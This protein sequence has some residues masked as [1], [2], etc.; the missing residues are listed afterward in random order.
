MGG[1]VADKGSLVKDEDGNVVAEVMDVQH[2]P[3]GQNMHTLKNYA[4]KLAKGMTYRLEVNREF[5]KQGQK[6][7]RDPLVGPSFT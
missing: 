5:R 4:K 7:H 1:Q 6:N 3:N 2:A